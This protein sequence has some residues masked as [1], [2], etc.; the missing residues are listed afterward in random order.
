[1][2]SMPSAAVLAVGAAVVAVAAAADMLCIMIFI[3][4]FSEDLLALGIV[5][6]VVF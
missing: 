1:M 6:S 4:S 2:V 5:L 3:F